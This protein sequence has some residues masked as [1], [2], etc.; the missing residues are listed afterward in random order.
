M[1]STPVTK[2]AEVN[3]FSAFFGVI[4][5]QLRDDKHNLRLKRQ[6]WADAPKS[7]QIEFLKQVR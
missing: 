5:R 3:H 2:D 1:K 4:L 7:S 6:R